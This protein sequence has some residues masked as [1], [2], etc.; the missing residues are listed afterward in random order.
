MGRAG[1][2]SGQNPTMNGRG[3]SDGPVVPMKLPNKTGQP[4]A[5]VVEGRGP[6]KGNPNQR[7]AFR[8][9]SR[10]GAPGALARV[11]EAARRDKKARFTALLHHVTVDRLRQAFGEISKDAAPGVDGMTW[12]QYA[13]ALEDNLQD[14]HG[15]LHRG[16]Y[17]A[18]P[19]RRVYIPKADGQRRALGVSSLEDKVVQRAVGEVLNTIYERD[20]LG[21]SY[22]FRPGRSQHDA[23]DALTVGILRKKVNWVLDADIRGFFDT[24]DHAWLMKFVEHRVGDKRVLRLIQQWLSAGVMENG[25]WARSKEG[26]PQGATISPLL[27]NVYLHYVYDLW[28]LQWRNRHAGGDMVVVRYADDIVAGF[29]YRA[30]AERFLHDLKERF[31]QFAL[32]LHPDKT[33][34]IEFGRFAAERRRRAG[35]GKPETFTFLGFTHICGKARS[36]N[37]LLLRHTTRPRMRAKLEKIGS[38]LKRCRH[39]PIA[40]QGQWVGSVVRGYLAY[41][42]IP[43]NTRATQAFRREVVKHWHR[44]LRRRGQR[45]RT[46]W[47]RM[48]ALARRWIP[49]ALVQHPWPTERFDGR[50]QGGSR[51]R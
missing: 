23:L 41:H 40:I 44:A 42:A 43:T 14:L 25:S 32:E 3:K 22:G 1:K 20:F 35:S 45:D 37:F 24:I 5:E 39:Q 12:P 10:A 9:Q 13:E 8:T 17:R 6:T 16:A 49:R 7:G 47:R 2:A 4:V 48:T 51:V 19:S 29:E 33:R 28:A 38:E 30:D 50:T 21:F 18:K 46:N 27:A 36:G 31:R 15:R 34:L 11:R 26:S